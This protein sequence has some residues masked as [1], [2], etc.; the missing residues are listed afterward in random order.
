MIWS[1]VNEGLPNIQVFDRELTRRMF[2][3]GNAWLAVSLLVSGCGGS[4]GGSSTSSRSYTKV[5]IDPSVI[6]GSGL[7]A[8]TVYQVKVPI[9][10]TTQVLASPTDVHHV[11]VLDGTGALR[12]MALSI[13]KSPTLV[14][15]T[16]TLNA[17]LFLTPGVHIRDPEEAA[18]RIAYM[19][20]RSPY[21]QAL[22]YLATNLPAQT[23]ATL[24]S[25][26][27]YVALLTAC[28]RDFMST[29]SVL[30]SG[31]QNGSTSDLFAVSA[32][33]ASGP[34]TMSNNA[35]RA[36]KVD[37]VDYDASGA[38]LRTVA[39]RHYPPT[40]M[41]GVSPATWGT[42]FSIGKADVET[43]SL[44]IDFTTAAKSEYWVQG[45]GFQAAETPPASV[46]PLAVDAWGISLVLYVVFPLLDIL[47]FALGETFN[48]G[49]AFKVAETLYS[50]VGDTQAASAVST[51]TTLSAKF[52]ATV[53]FFLTTVS[54]AI[55]YSTFVDVGMYTL[56][57]LEAMS[58]LLAGLEILSSVFGIA[59]AGMA[60]ANLVV[61]F[62]QWGQY[63]PC[64]HAD[65]LS[66]GVGSVT[67]G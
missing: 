17:A 28:I 32:S 16:S 60:A 3:Y 42:L 64:E 19:A 21:Q 31:L 47:F 25:S 43:D 15:A 61:V 65:I 1:A 34:V 58:A 18:K 56:A 33:K 8:T 44:S 27:T 2:L 13:P 45:P 26:D 50:L 10:S 37:R 24:L 39:V 52:E 9:T 29:Y 57:E 55:E 4:G 40:I 41:G 30:P 5:S 67:V 6:T 51:A 66:T 12:G 22:A 38:I 20:A 23:F 49:S 54:Q 36:L 48:D 53:D 62:D 46:S 7:T 14:N 63:C 11:W 59:A 35:W